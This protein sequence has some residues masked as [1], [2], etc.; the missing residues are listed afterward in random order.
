[1]DHETGTEDHQWQAE[2]E[3]GKFEV[4]GVANIYP[5][6]DAPDRR[7][8]IVNLEHVSCVGDAKVIHDHA[9]IVEVKVPAVE[10][11]EEQGG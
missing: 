2:E 10:G 1:M 4:L 5:K 6:H 8:D 3:T 11:E 9:E 7:A